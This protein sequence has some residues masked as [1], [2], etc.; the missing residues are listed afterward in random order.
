MN[1]ELTEKRSAFW[2][3]AELAG[4]IFQVSLIAYLVFY[5]IEDLK[6][7]FITDYF[8]LNILLILTILSG[9]LTVLFKKEGAEKKEEVVKIRKKDY[10]FVVILG[11]VTTGLIYY[12]IRETGWLA[13]VISIISGVIIILMSILL[14]WDKGEEEEDREKEKEE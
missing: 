7:G 13:P 2:F 4:E 14:L 5:L 10:I 8:N 3:L 11:I 6:A 12:R 1:Q 9:V